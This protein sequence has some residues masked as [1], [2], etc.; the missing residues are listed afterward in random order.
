M[1]LSYQIPSKSDFSHPFTMSPYYQLKILDNFKIQNKLQ[2]SALTMC[3]A[4][5]LGRGD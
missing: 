2:S 4:H 5:Q 1:Y 3:Y